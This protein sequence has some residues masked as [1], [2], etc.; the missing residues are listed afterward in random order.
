MSEILEAGGSMAM[1]VLAL[2]ALGALVTVGLGAVSFLQRRVPLAAWVF[3]PILVCIVGAIG[4]WSGA[5][6]IFTSLE[7]ADA[8]TMNQTAMAG[9]WQS[10]TIDWF[11][12]WVAAFLLVLAS[13][14]TGIG[15]TIASGPADETRLTPVAAAFSALTAVIGAAGLAIYGLGYGLALE[16]QLL[17]ATV[18]FGGLGV[19][20]SSTRRALYEHAYRVAGLRFTSAACMVL[21]V[22]YGGKA[23]SMGTQ[24][25]MFGP[26]GSAV[27]L[28]LPDAVIA[29]TNVADPIWNMAWVAFGVALL[30]AFF[31]FFSELGEIMQRYT[32]IDVGATLALVALLATVRVVEESRTNA[33][34]DVATH[35]PAREIFDSWGT[36]LPAGVLTVNKTPLRATP[37]HGGYGDVLEFKD[38]VIGADAEGKPVSKREWRR[39]W[40]WTGSSWYADDRPLDCAG[41][42]PGC[43]PA[44]VG[45]KRVPLLAISKSDDASTLIEAGRKMPGGEFMLLLRTVEISADK[46]IPR[47][48]AHEQ[49]GFLPIRVEAPTDLT[50]ELWVDAGYKEVFWGPTHWF[51]EEEDREP[52]IYSDAVFEQTSAPGIHALISERARVEGVAGSC[53]A[54]AMHHDDGRAVP[55]GK[56]CSIA[57]GSVEAWRAKAR[58]V[59]PQPEPDSVSLKVRVEGP[60]DAAYFEDVFRRETD[61][62]A[63]CQQKAHEKAWEEYDPDDKE[64]VLADTFGRMEMSVVINDRGRIN[65][66]YVEDKSKLQ[67]SEISRCAAKRYRKLEFEPLPPTPQVEGQEKPAPPTATIW[68][69]YDFKKLP[70]PSK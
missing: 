53:L 43:Q 19:A 45:S 25:A 13:W 41:H 44:V 37:R 51:G 50:K 36:D 54:A 40:E 47:Q 38:F 60:V 16:A 24:I 3:L 26:R 1:I 14:A 67:N 39:T 12:R 23:V 49:L 42:A 34:A 29:W 2:G 35:A 10:L 57:E 48:L 32:L 6:S 70:P 52:L 62:I 59:W 63:F 17:A 18:L 7:A 15:A 68:L 8:D 28:D 9:L 33:L 30:V 64:S 55:S 65:G 69:T 27:G 5:G 58:E 66:T 22:M 21:A 46:L 56:W 11:A 61:A 20:F 4:A 31:G